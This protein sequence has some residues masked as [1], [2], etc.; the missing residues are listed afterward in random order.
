MSETSKQAAGS[1]EAEIIR[2][3]AGAASKGVVEAAEESVEAIESTQDR[4]IDTVTAG[5]QEAIETIESASQAVLEAFT[6][7][8]AEIS[9]FVAE[10]IRQD[11]DTQQAFLRCRNFDEVRDVQVQ[12]LRTALDQY[13]GEVAA[14]S[15]DRPRA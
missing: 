7:A 9:D 13:G 14:R 11:L 1:A 2:G 3:Q 8:R 12:Y 6:R 10:R 15:L 4:L 5:Q